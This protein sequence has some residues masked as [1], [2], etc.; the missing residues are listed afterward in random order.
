[1]FSSQQCS[2]AAYIISDRIFEGKIPLEDKD[3]DAKIL[4]KG[5]LNKCGVRL[6]SGLN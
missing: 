6:S 3:S 4:L 2:R 5:K 1:M